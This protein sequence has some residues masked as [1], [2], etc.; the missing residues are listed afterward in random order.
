MLKKLIDFFKAPAELPVTMDE[1]QVKKAYKKG[2]IDIFSSCFIG[3]TV[4]HLTRKNIATA[5]PA[6]STDLGYS[7]TQLGILG[8]ALYFAYAFG[9]FINGVIA[10]KADARKFITTALFFSSLANIAFALSS[11]YIPVDKVVFGQPLL[12]TVMAFFWGVNGW[13]Q[14]MGFPGIA[15]SLA[16]WW[17]NKERGTVWSLWTTSHQLG[18][19]LAFVLAGYLIPRLGWQA[20]FIIPG[21]INLVVCIYLYT[22]MHDKPESLGLPDVEIFKEGKKEEVEEVVDE[23]AHMS[24]IDILKKYVFLNPTMWLLAFAFTFVY[25]CRCGTE[26][27]II[28]YLCEIKH[29]SLELASQKQTFLPFFGIAGTLLAGV[30]SDKI[31]KGKRMPVTFI[32][33]A[34]FALCVFGLLENQG[35]SLLATIID[36]AC[37]AGIGFFTAGPQMF[38]GGICAV[39]TGSK[40]VASAATGFCGIFGYFGAILSGIGTGIFVDNFGWAGALYFWIAAAICCMLVLIPVYRKGV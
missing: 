18:T 9:K 16:F 2:R 30:F 38:V 19:C 20:A 28:K 7:N 34:G 15:K 4:F 6:L 40:K 36:Y 31:F 3:Y 13:F 10:D 27:W 33:L 26:D 8:S 23:E 29:N 5:L 1:E 37:I 21:I 17:S 32:F 35:N 11:Y 25:I 24:Y 39:E 14:S 12:L 22:H